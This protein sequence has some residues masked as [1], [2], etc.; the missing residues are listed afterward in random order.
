MGR[1]GRLFVRAWY[2]EDSGGYLLL[3]PEDFGD[4]AVRGCDEWFPEADPE[5]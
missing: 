3:F 1:Y 2:D 5:G 4:S